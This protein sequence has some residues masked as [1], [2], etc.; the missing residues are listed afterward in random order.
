MNTKPLILFI[1]LSFALSTFLFPQ[2]TKT[3]AA[4]SNPVIDSLKL[5]LANSK[6]AEDS[7]F[8]LC[9]LA[10]QTGSDL[11]QDKL[12]Y[13][14]LALEK[15]NRITDQL[16]I[17]EAYDAAASGY[18]AVNKIETTKKLFHKSLEI[19]EKNNYP[20]RIG[21]SSYHL[22]QI[23]M[24]EGNPEEAYS[25]VTKSK[26]AFKQSGSSDMILKN[27]WLLLKSNHNNRKNNI[28]TLITDIFDVI[29]STDNP[30]EILFHYL[31]LSRLYNMLENKTQSMHFVQLAMEIAD[32]VENQNGLTKAYHSIAAYFRDDQK[33]YEAALT[34]YNKIYEIQ[35]KQD[36]P[37]GIAWVY[38]EIGT[39]YKL[40]EKDSLAL[41]YLNESLKLA[42]NENHRHYI[43]NAYMNIGEIN[44]IKQ[45]YQEALDYYLKCYKT[46]CDFCPQINFHTAL[47]NLGNVYLNSKDYKNSLLYYNKALALSDSANANYER[48]ISYL[49][50]AKYYAEQGKNRESANN[51]KTALDFAK[52]TNS[53]QLQA[54]INNYLG[55]IYYD[56]G[57][58]KQ[59]YTYSEQSKIL[60]DSL[61][62]I[63][64]VDNL[65]KLE[66]R[67]EF[68]NLQMQKEFDK[69]KSEQEIA[70]Q[71][72]I[73]NL[74]VLG[75]VLVGI[76]GFIIFLSYRRKKKDNKLLNEQNKAIE[77]MSRKIHEADQAK[78]QFFTNVSHELRTPLTIILGITEKFKES[79]K[80]QQ[81]T[82]TIRKNS[83][84]LLQLINHLLDLRKLDASKM[85]L[86]VSEGNIIDFL[87]GIKSSF[88]EYA[89]KK[90][91]S[92]QIQASEKALSGY[93]D[94][95][96]LEK[97]LTN[98]ISNAIKYNRENGSVTISV[99]KNS[100]GYTILGIE[101]TGLGISEK[102]IK[103]IFA[104]FYRVPENNIHG[105]GIGL[106][107]V[108]ELVELHKGEI[109][110]RSVKNE[111]TIFSVKIPTER[112]FYTDNEIKNLD[113][114]AN[115]WEH[116]E[117]VDTDDEV[118][119][120]KDFV[121]NPN[122][123]TLLI[124]E[125]N[126]D[127]RKFIADIFSEEYEV[128]KASDGEEG[129][130][131][132]HKYVPDLII[133]D[134]IMPKVSGIQLVEKVKNDITTSHIPIILLTAKKDFGTHLASFEKGADDYIN[135]PF[136]S[137]ILKS[138]VENLLRLR[139]QLVEKF[140]KQ[141]H[142]EPKEITIDDADQKFLE[143]TIQ[144]IEKQITEPNL[145]IDFLA[146][147]LGVSRTQLYRKL[148][149]LTDYSANQFIRVIRLKRA[150]QIL[151]QGQN[152]IAEVM[153]ATGF[154]NYSHFNNCFKEYFG[155]LPKDY[156]LLTV[157]GSMN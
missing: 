112:L 57:D 104:R 50:L 116:S 20:V 11:P 130:Q 84:K 122:K 25:F 106:A 12:Y 85:P 73:R 58:F 29:E 137:A 91:I 110:V 15:S 26:K 61:E 9:R 111:G 101:D 96:K 113:N 44:Y 22:A 3:D 21:Y 120:D 138:R 60:S 45:N 59:A 4:S 56:L 105:S 149:A 157:K 118:S 18:W 35:K 151:K 124:V 6:T 83:L 62:N 37:L 114:G 133:S 76:L 63:S 67:F 28:D 117:I 47:I 150:A 135:K 136:S 89:S 48:A 143:K 39:C 71:K 43:S 77:R 40:M 90:N 81:I 142:L 38:N 68:Q 148:K 70:R 155:E 31:S 41:H 17:S 8:W 64:K 72:L 132:S 30:D 27:G 16:K 103:N 127:L 141:F 87:K 69:A 146:L 92:I 33:N 145:N 139:K 98:I 121:P 54:D 86:E 1:F 24:Q 52:K 65:A 7:I 153:D 108:K 80:E 82:H 115:L 95:D 134:I 13:G 123:Q 53:L 109:S 34:Y 125:D 88:D 10:W 147:E 144:I 32:E 93:F 55:G 152:N 94:H 46:G 128:L 156:A 154:S 107:L 131:L 119:L 51:F 140:S 102:E 66:T 75:L 36:L 23:A 126:N 97:V 42:K 2:K 78:L 74:F 129:Y 5:E 14:K 99:E 19:G 49:S 100:D 79:V